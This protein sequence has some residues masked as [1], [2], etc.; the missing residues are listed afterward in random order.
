MLSSIL[1]KVLCVSHISQWKYI[2]RNETISIQAFQTFISLLIYSTDILWVPEND[3]LW[4]RA[5][6]RVE[7]VLAWTEIKYSQDWKNFG[8]NH[9]EIPES[10]PNIFFLI[11]CGKL[12]TSGT[13]NFLFSYTNGLT[14]HS[15]ICCLSQFYYS[16]L[17]IETALIYEIIWQTRWLNS[18][19][20]IYVISNYMLYLR[21]ITY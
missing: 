3:R 9:I 14:H 12:K 8:K 16:D 7:M 20:Y 4:K 18:T 11:Q 21:W 13:I 1:T 10:L 6:N 17:S 2:T 5:L 19:I 15:P